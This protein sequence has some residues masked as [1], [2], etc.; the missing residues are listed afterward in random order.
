M[1]DLWS[2]PAQ[3]DLLDFLKTDP[4][5]VF[6]YDGTLCPIVVHHEDAIIPPRQRELFARLCERRP[7]AILTGRARG[8]ILP[9]L[10][11]L[12]LVQV[13]GSHGAEWSRPRPGDDEVR[14]RNAVWKR[15]IARAIR[16][17]DG[18]EI[19]DKGLSLSVHYRSA[20]DHAL[21]IK[22]ITEAVV[23]LHDARV[24]GG[25]EVFNVIPRECAGKGQALVE[26]KQALGKHSALFVGDDLT[27]EEVFDL[28]ASDNVFKIRVGE[29]P[30][31]R[32][33]YLIRSQLEMERLLELL[34]GRG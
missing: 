30:G 3:K 22:R 19:E 14:A 28:P 24:I 33:E 25:K 31:T 21:A 27:D 9:K 32:A 8:D 13:V 34:L 10:E 1:Q 26:L 7:C 17:L 18:V 29:R 11:G 20:E 12:H 5:L 6:D 4:L 2:A 16:G 23:E 15:E